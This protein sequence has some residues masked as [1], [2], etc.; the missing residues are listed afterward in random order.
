MFKDTKYYHFNIIKSWNKVDIF[1]EKMLHRWDFCGKLKSFDYKVQND[2]VLLRR[3][4]NI[5]ITYH[6]TPTH[7]RQITGYLLLFVIY[8]WHRLIVWEASEFSQEVFYTE[9]K[10]HMMTALF[11]ALLVSMND[12]Q[13]DRKSSFD[14]PLLYF[15]ALYG[16]KN[17]VCKSNMLHLCQ[18]CEHVIQIWDKMK[19]LYLT[20]FLERH[21]HNH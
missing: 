4:L 10:T 13:V 15:S 1:Y 19:C 21:F 11:R 5:G 20:R 6:S 7:N 16:L 2:I 14:H 3:Y 18:Q 9:M 12:C 8:K 17:L